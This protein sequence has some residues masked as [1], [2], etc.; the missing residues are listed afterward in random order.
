VF[1]GTV[2][3]ANLDA[4]KAL[5]GIVDAFIVRASEANPSGDPQGVADG[6]AI[7]KLVACE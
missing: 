6:V 5:P 7:E 2:T 3:S 1:G 4:L